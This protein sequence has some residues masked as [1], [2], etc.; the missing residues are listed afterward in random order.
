MTYYR[1]AEIFTSINGEGKKAGQLSVFIR[2]QGCNLRCSYCDTRWANGADCA[3]S[4]MTAEEITDTVRVSGISNVTLTGGEP[5]S[6]ENIRGLL[7][8]LAAQ[9]ALSVEI[10]TNGSIPLAPFADLTNRPSFT[11]DYK[12]PGS[13]MEQAMYLP[14]FDVLGRHDTVKFVVSDRNDLLQAKEIISRY[15]LNGR[16]HVYLSPVFG[17]I[18]PEEIVNFMKKY[19]MNGVTLQL[20]LHKIIWD[21]QARGV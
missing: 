18:G 4:L 11:M 16:T 17:K 3:Y 9:P 2:L 20:Q 1:V 10:E 14:N 6:H 5:L 19:R 8:H 21:P 7:E 13:G 12:L 15:D